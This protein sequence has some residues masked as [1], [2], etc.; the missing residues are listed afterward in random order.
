QG[1]QQQIIPA[2]EL[3]W[4][5]RLKSGHF[6]YYKDVA[7][8]FAQMVG[9]DPWFIEPLFK[10]CGEVDFMQREGENCLTKYVTE[11]LDAIQKKY[12]EYHIDSKPFVIVKADAGTY[13]MAVMTVR[14]AKELHSLNRKQRTHMAKSKG[15]QPVQRVIVQEGVYTFETWG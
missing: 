15:G 8:E 7:F 6:Q 11:L 13:G 10:H 2:A 14:D 4:S 12:D 1:L 5:Q 9:I 3:G